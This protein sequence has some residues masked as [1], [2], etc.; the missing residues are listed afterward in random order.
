LSRLPE[1]QDLFA[2]I[3]GVRRVAIVS[4]AAQEDIAEWDSVGHLNLMLGLEASFG[5][6]LEVEDMQTLTSVSAILE[7]LESRCRSS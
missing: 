6:Q 4:G 7:F 3:L 5:V 2:E 1:L